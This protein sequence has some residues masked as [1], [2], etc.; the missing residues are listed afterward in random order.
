MIFFIL[1]LKYGAIARIAIARIAIARQEKSASPPIGKDILLGKTSSQLTE[2]K[3]F[4]LYT[5][6]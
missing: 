6:C 2:C 5:V 4:S 3:L 1:A